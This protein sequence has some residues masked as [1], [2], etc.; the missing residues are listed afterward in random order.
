MCDP[1]RVEV[2]VAAG[3]KRG[4]RVT[5]RLPAEVADL[6]GGIEKVLDGYLFD[7]TVKVATG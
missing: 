6:R 3:G 5:I 7:Y 2:D 1:D 4:T